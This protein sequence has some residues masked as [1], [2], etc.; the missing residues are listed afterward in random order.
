MSLIDD[1]LTSARVTTTQPTR[2][3]KMPR[4][5][6]ETLLGADDKLAVKVYRSFIGA[7]SLIDVSA[8]QL[9]AS[10]VIDYV[11]KAGKVAPKV[12]GRIVLR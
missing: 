10:Q 6:F 9:M 4:A 7:K 1:L 3:L 12:E 5:A 11:A 2:L 8:S